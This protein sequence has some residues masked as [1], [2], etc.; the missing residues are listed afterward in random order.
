MKYLLTEFNDFLKVPPDRLETCLKEFS[1]AVL[2]ASAAKQLALALGD[3]ESVKFTRLEW[4]DDGEK[5]LTM[6]I[7][8]EAKP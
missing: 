6:K 7:N 8:I 2:M 4:N 1:E 3:T 5:N